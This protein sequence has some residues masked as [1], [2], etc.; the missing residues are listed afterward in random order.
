MQLFQDTTA[1]GAPL[2]PLGTVP[3]P[4][5][6]TTTISGEGF[7]SS[8]APV[9]GRPG[10]FYGLTDRGPNADDPL[11]NK[12]EPLPNFTPEI[13]EFKLVDG[14]AELQK[15]ITLKGPKNIKG[16]QGVFGQ[17][18]S[19]RPPA[20]DTKET[21]DNVAQSHGKTGVPVPSDP[22]GYDSEGLVALPDGTFWVSD[23]YG[24]YITHF[25]ANGYEIGRLT[26]DQDSPNNA[27]HKI[28]GY[29]PAELPTASTTRAWRA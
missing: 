8:L 13:G 2:P 27:F 7:G 4:N 5:G 28:V 22:D 18:Y 26:P 6:T 19:G 11:G 16:P 17:P 29:L 25:D 9:P 12:S 21:I 3:G 10:W 20:P 24:P 15:T 14:K 1:N 23:E